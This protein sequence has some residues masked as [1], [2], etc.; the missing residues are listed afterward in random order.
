MMSPNCLRV[1]LRA[2]CE[3]PVASKA[4]SNP[5][6][7]WIYLFSNLSADFLHTQGLY[8]CARSPFDKGRQVTDASKTL[9][10]F[11]VQV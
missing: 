11:I 9:N 2:E 3:Y 1:K 10:S 8:I 5:L 7:R 6:A 4:G